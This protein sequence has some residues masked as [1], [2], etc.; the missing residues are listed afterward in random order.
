MALLHSE[1]EILL[2]WIT[3]EFSRMR[4]MRN[5]DRA[6]NAESYPTLRY[7]ELYLLD[8]GY[9]SFYNQY[10][11]VCCPSFGYTPM[12]DQ[13]HSRDLRKFKTQ[14]KSTVVEQRKCRTT[15][16]ATGKLFWPVAW[17]N[18]IPPATVCF[19]FC[20][21]DTVLHVKIYSTWIGCWST[22]AGFRCRGVVAGSCCWST[23]AGSLYR[24]TVAGSL[25]RGC[26]ITY[27]VGLDGSFVL[28][29][30]S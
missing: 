19:Q 7:P 16:R 29:L 5:N 25:Y 17:W 22:V 8:G 13:Q 18:N 12:Y 6:M 4:F 3:Y 2:T 30:F 27:H 26:C 21:L 15:W 1:Q 28:G 14:V 11:S 9:Q 23:V 10:G 20:I 24:S